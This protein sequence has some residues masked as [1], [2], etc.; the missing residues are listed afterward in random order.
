MADTLE[1]ARD[2][3]IAWL[4]QDLEREESQREVDVVVETPKLIIVQEVESTEE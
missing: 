4:V 2:E 1:G 3:D